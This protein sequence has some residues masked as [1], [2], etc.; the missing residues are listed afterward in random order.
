MKV[1]RRTRG[2][3]HRSAPAASPAGEA[4]RCDADPHWSGPR[5]RRA[6]RRRVQVSTGH[7]SLDQ[8]LGALTAAGVDAERVYNR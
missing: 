8:Q 7:Q 6:P 2:G 1:R 4:K 3:K 5:P